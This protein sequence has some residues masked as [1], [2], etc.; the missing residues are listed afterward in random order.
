MVKQD[1]LKDVL[2]VVLLLAY[3]T[4]WLYNQKINYRSFFH[5]DKS[6]LLIGSDEEQANLASVVEVMTKLKDRAGNTELLAKTIATSD[7]GVLGRIVETEYGPLEIYEYAR[8]K[9]AQSYLDS[10]K[11]PRVVRYKN[12]LIIYNIQG[13]Q[14]L[15]DALKASLYEETI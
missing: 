5:Y 7:F 12:L 2:L 3:P 14:K 10:T 8:V 15:L 1:R 4:L 9:Y 6:M 11:N 13:E